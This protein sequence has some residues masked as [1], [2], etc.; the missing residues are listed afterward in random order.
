[1]PTCLQE[2]L[3][4]ITQIPIEQIPD[5]DG[6]EWR[7]H[8]EAWLDG[9]GYKLHLFDHKLSMIYYG[10]TIAKGP[11]ER[12]TEHA[13]IMNRGEL[14]YDQHPSKSGLTQIRYH[15]IVY[16]AEPANGSL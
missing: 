5:F 3:T 16:K 4:R 6:T 1:M 8:L 9:R 10:D 12:G 15:M 13:V 14:V 2:C 7:P 11:T